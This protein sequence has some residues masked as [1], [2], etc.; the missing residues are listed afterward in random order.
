MPIMGCLVLI[1]LLIALTL[2]YIVPKRWPDLRI[3]NHLIIH[4]ERDN[5]AISCPFKGSIWYG[6]GIMPP[7]LLSL[8]NI[9][10]LRV[11]CAIIAVLSVG[12]ST[13]TWFGKFFGRI[14][15]GHK[16]LEGFLAFF[17]LGSLSA[18]L[19]VQNYRLALIL[20]F[21]GA[22]LEFFT[23]LDDN[24]FIPVGLTI[25]YCILNIIVPNLIL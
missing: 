19:F 5:D 1:P 17:V 16:S 15:I 11:A 8:A 13:S 3:A 10:P 25:L 12:D 22:I 9:M 21:V 6:I 7:L 23:L 18:L 14:R 24:F 2:L 20:G 4:F